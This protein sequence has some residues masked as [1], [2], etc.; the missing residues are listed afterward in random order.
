MKRNRIFFL[1]LRKDGIQIELLNT[2]ALVLDT[3]SWI[4]LISSVESRKRK[5]GKKSLFLFAVWFYFTNRAKRIV[6]QLNNRSWY[7]LW[8]PGAIRIPQN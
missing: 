8:I 3:T 2:F 7:M 4:F 6:L 5:R 1:E